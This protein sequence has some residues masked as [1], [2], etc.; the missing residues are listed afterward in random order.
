MAKKLIEIEKD[1]LTLSDHD[2]TALAQHLIETLD[3]DEDED[4]EEVWLK[5]A[6]RR[7]K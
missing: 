3:K 2:R 6:E 4:V 7:Y 5:E 1:A